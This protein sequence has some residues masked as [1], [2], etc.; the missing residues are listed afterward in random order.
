MPPFFRAIDPSFIN[1]RSSK[2][3]ND[4]RWATALTQRPTLHP[5]PNRLPNNAPS[6]NTTPLPPRIQL[7]E[8]GGIF[9]PETPALFP[10]SELRVRPWCWGL[11]SPLFIYIP[12]KGTV[13][14]LHNS[15]QSS[16]GVSATKSVLKRTDFGLVQSDLV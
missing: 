9:P 7:P 1:V 5:S 6:R 12:K 10:P 15:L 4:Y 16:G 13:N 11:A 2:R 8:V 14:H 3:D